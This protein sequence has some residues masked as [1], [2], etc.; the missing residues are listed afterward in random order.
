MSTSPVIQ[1]PD[2]TLSIPPAPL[3]GTKADTSNAAAPGVDQDRM[4]MVNPPTSSIVVPRGRVI[5]SDTGKVVQPD[6][7]IIQ[8]HQD[9]P[10]PLHLPA[11]APRKEV[12]DLSRELH[13]LWSAKGR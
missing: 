4:S 1:N 6:D 9:M 12:E 2:I 11:N 10:H 8:I 3:S 7:Y 13:E 5:D